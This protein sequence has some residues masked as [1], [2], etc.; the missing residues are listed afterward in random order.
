MAAM[1]GEKATEQIAVEKEHLTYCKFYFYS[2]SH[3]VTASSLDED[4]YTF[5]KKPKRKTYVVCSLALLH[6]N[7]TRYLSSAD[8]SKMTEKS[9]EKTKF[10]AHHK[11]NLHKMLCA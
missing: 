2:D 5:C 7:R 11:S 3:S 4:N 8:V 10:I 9:L 6:Y 1:R